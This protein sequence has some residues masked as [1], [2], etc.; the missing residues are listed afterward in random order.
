MN[1]L[2][3]SRYGNLGASSRLRT[4]QYVPYMESQGIKIQVL[5]LLDNDYVR[6]LYSSDVPIL[7]IVRSYI[8]RVCFLIKMERF[9]LIWVEKEVLPWLPAFFENVL[10]PSKTPI[11]V[12]YDD[13]QFH[14]Y[15]QHKSPFVRAVLGHKIQ[16][17]MAMA[18]VVVVGNEYL[19]EYAVSA[20]AR[21]VE[22]VPTVVDV[23]RYTCNVDSDERMLTIGWIG[24]P[25]TDKYL[26]LLEPVFKK[27][28]ESNCVRIVAIGA[29]S[30]NL[31]GIPVET[32]KWAESD[33]VK[34]ILKFDIGIMP[35]PDEPWERGKCGYKL[36]QYMACCKPVIA[37]PVGINLALVQQGINGFLADTI[38]DWIQ[39]FE[40]LLSDA[41]LRHSMGQSGRNL[42]E[43][44]YSLGVTAPKLKHIFR[45]LVT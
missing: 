35:L 13:A 23:E 39:A 42:V 27:I 32:K 7:S 9:D 4:Y 41:T 34:E 12:D 26:R 20:G 15:D 37:S 33:E 11:V 38:Q 6:G 24:T 44:K 3:L 14:R 10:L 19:A 25:T 16:N 36:I 40:R 21:K 45:S 31:V 8:F 30:K 1:I 29:N 28:V 18:N 22:I 5:P 17:I 2:L 43:Q